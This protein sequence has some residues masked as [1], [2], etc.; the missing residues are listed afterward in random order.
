M[1]SI[2]HQG[3]TAK[4]LRLYACLQVL[5]AFVLSIHMHSPS[6]AAVLNQTSMLTDTRGEGSGASTCNVSI[7][8]FSILTGTV[9]NTP[10][11]CCQVRI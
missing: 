7:M 11:I 4:S 8:V 3:S 5:V 9:E 2:F 10:T 1:R 6:Q